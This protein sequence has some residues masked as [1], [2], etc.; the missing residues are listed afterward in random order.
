MSGEDTALHEWS[1]DQV[2]AAVRARTVSAEEVTRAHF[3]RIRR[4]D[5]ALGAFLTV[6]EEGA[7]A[8]ARQLDAAGK[9][10]GA[11]ADSERPL[12]GVP[13]A[14]K[15]LF[16]TRGLTTTAGSR[17]LADYRPPYDATVVE[18]LRRAGAVVLGKTNLDEFA[19]GSSTENSAYQV[20][21]NPWD[22]SRAPGG[23]SGGSAVAVASRLSTLSLGTDTG[24]SIRQPAALCGVTGLR[25]T[26]GRISRYGVIA[27]ASS[28]DQPGPFGRSVA[29]VAR[30][31]QAVA[32]HDPADATSL[33]EPAPDVLS[34]L[35][36]GVRG[37]RIGVPREFFPA[38]L[39]ARVE[40]AVR[41]GLSLLAREGAELVEVSLPHS[42]HA[43]ACYYLVATAEASSNL[44]RYD[45]VRYGLRAA[46]APSLSA[47]YEQTRRQGFGAE[48]KRR[49]LLGTYALS[50]GYYDAFY[51]R[52]Q[53]VRALIRDDFRAAFQRCDVLCTPTSPFP[54]F[55]LG[56]KV[57][58]PLQM[59]LAD[60]FTLGV[61]L[62]GVCGVSV[63]CGLTAPD[64][65]AGV[66]A[67][68]LGLQLIG[69]PFDEAT[70]L[71]V[72]RAHER[73]TDWHLRR[74][75]EPAARVGGPA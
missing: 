27:F 34:G 56:E 52:A 63:P 7:L 41:A 38:G 68:P 14:L 49:I 8:A 75:P 60:I 74:P 40:A 64:P 48:V 12:L 15:D 42:A 1:A 46:D 71:R 4:L 45:G 72:A 61:N 59:Y 65:A 30:A 66:P 35:E 62:A 3:D 22:L 11:T 43:V 55:R 23:S 39:D 33:P 5:G 17:I 24:G 47:M 18:R 28:L 37:L 36:Q 58:D 53:K 69:R 51:L 57:D 6:D 31:L 25:P 13:V 29:D 16:C 44:A 50:A 67:L 32:G 54:A 73:A 10:A 70:L 20:T 2:A 19:M 21:K 9:N 26:Y